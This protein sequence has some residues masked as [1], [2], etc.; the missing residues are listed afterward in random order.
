MDGIDAIEWLYEELHWF[1][2]W[3]APIGLS[4]EHLGTLRC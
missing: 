3:D 4:K 1:G 2:F